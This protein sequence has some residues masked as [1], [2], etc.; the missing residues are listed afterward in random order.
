[1]K[2]RKANQENHKE[3]NNNMKRKKKRPNATGSFLFGRHIRPPT[4]ADA[5]RNQSFR[6]DSFQI[7]ARDSWENAVG[8]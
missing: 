1:M 6:N 3:N 4:P 5:I 8:C 2:A 7:L